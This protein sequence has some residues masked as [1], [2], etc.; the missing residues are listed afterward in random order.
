MLF[1]GVNCEA[2]DK[3]VKV[4]VRVNGEIHE[5]APEIGR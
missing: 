2:P 4:K 3:S 1:G 5:V